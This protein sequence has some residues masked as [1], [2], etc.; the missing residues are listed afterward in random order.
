VNKYQA[1][2]HADYA[3]DHKFIA[4]WGYGPRAPFADPPSK[5]ETLVAF[6]EKYKVGNLG[7]TFCPLQ[8]QGN[9]SAPGIG[10]SGVGCF[11]NVISRWF[12]K[13]YDTNIW[14]KS[15]V[16]I[17][18]YGL[19]VAEILSIQGWLMLLYEK[20]MITAEDTD[21]IPMEW[22]SQEATVALIDKIALQ[23][24]FGKYFKGGAIPA[25]DHIG[26]EDALNLALVDRNNMYPLDYF[27]ER[28]AFIG[29]VGG[30]QLL[31]AATQY[32]WIEPNSDVL[33]M[34]Q[35]VA[36]ALGLSGEEA[37]ELLEEWLSE[38]SSKHTGNKD[39]WR[40]QAVE[41][42]AKYLAANENAIISSDISGKCDWSTTKLAQCGF[43][44]DTEDTAKAVCAATGE[45]CSLERMLD[46]VQK[47]RIMEIAYNI[48][49]EMMISEFPVVSDATVAMF[50][51][52]TKGGE[53]DGCEWDEEG[54]ETVGEEYCHIRGCDPET[55]VPT[56]KE[57]ER[58]RL[59]YIADRLEEH[60]LDVGSTSDDEST[61]IE[62]AEGP[63]PAKEERSKARGRRSEDAVSVKAI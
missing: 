10:N 63:E 62:D 2:S 42:K 44:W 13:T 43:I 14:W 29:G 50:T 41:G 3:T 8:C 5:E 15:I 35:P 27:A 19:N 7:C 37:I 34:Y 52:P 48:L 11:T 17:N 28:G 61:Y 54:T 25:S 21:G 53:F 16:L 56:R 58:L 22:G 32:F 12:A 18:E 9:Y 60:G 59:K 4:R 1:A 51:E 39:A 45:K 40:A 33:G 36:K 46:V 6:N 57:L 30:S 24:G 38:L 26:G 23:E 20:G 31:R 49:C 47:K 55:G